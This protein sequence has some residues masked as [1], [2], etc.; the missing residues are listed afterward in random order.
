MPLNAGRGLPGRSLHTSTK[1][2]TH[3][4]TALNCSALC[5]IGGM[6]PPAWQQQQH[7]QGC[8]QQLQQQLGRPGVSCSSRLGG[9]RGRGNHIAAASSVGRRQHV[10]VLLQRTTSSVSTAAASISSPCASTAT[11]S[12]APFAGST[13][14]SHCCCSLQQPAAPTQQQ[15]QQQQFLRHQQQQ[16]QRSAHIARAAS[17]PPP[18]PWRQPPGGGGGAAAATDWSSGS[19]SSGGPP[20]DYPPTGNG[21]QSPGASYDAWDAAAPQRPVNGTP[22]YEQTDWGWSGGQLG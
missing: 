4:G 17:Q 7:A 13:R 10:Q 5:C 22:R 16:C 20:G 6:L 3:L 1:A 14:S 11:S 9:L 18:D 12:L 8:L 19:G 15:Q 21:R 2:T